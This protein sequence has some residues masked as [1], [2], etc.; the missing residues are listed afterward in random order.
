M[1]DTVIKSRFIN[2]HDIEENW[3]KAGN[4]AN[5]FI[6]KQGELIV[7]DD[8]YTDKS[9]EIIIVADNVRFKI[10]DGVNNVNNLPSIAMDDIYV[11]FDNGDLATFIEIDIPNLGSGDE[12]IIKA[13]DHSLGYSSEYIVAVD[14]IPSL[15]LTQV[16]PGN[17]LIGY[18]NTDT[19]H[20]LIYI[21]NT[22]S[23]T[24]Q[25]KGR[26]FKIDPA[27]TFTRL[28]ELPDN[29]IY[30]EDS[31]LLNYSSSQIDNKFDN[32]AEVA[33]TG[34]IN[35]I[36]QPWD[37]ELIFDGGIFDGNIAKLDDTELA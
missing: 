32:L 33:K 37:I 23:V 27:T 17:H 4:A 5:P 3:I 2:K 6:P 11:T 7:Y 31:N 18:M 20:P 15:F 10:G 29:I 1:S 12:L 24:L 35:N 16:I 30:F 25:L 9:G 34:S 21:N 36:E 8:R 19:G 13:S 14:K 28:D 22:E 26:N